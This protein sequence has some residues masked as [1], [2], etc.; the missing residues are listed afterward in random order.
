MKKDNGWF[1]V[2]IY[3]ATNGTL[4]VDGFK[5]VGTSG[6]TLSG[7]FIECRRRR[8]RLGPSRSKT[9]S[10]RATGG[11]II[12]VGGAMGDASNSKIHL[13]GDR[14]YLRN[15]LGLINAQQGGSG[16]N[17]VATID[18]CTIVQD[19]AFD[20][21]SAIGFLYGDIAEA[22]PV[23]HITNSIF[24]DTTRRI[25]MASGAS[26]PTHDDHGISVSIVRPRAMISLP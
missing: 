16:K 2:F 11:T 13:I 19:P 10:S 6:K 8:L 22:K 26:L 25:S 21:G 7:G 1:N 20:V 4:T 24:L 3:L 15:H 14:M 12:N 9:A 23:Y 17:L 5:I 18:R